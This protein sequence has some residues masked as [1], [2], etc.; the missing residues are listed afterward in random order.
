MIRDIEFL[1]PQ[2]EGLDVARALGVFASR[3]PSF[4]GRTCRP[5]MRAL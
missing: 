4:L 2:L 5:S 1:L 3:V